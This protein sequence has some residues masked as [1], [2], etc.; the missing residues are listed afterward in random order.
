MISDSPEMSSRTV[1]IL[2][3]NDISNAAMQSIEQS[4][5]MVME[6]DLNP[7]FFDLKSG[8]AGEV[9]QKFVNYRARLA[10]IVYDQNSHGER[11]SELIY[12]HRTHPMVRFFATQKEAQDW[13]TGSG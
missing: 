7:A 4:G 6:A 3:L 9:L 13:L 10:V 2:S 11:F 8:F 5:A 12:E 1:A